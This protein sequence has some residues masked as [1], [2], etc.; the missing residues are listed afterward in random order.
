LNEKEIVI[1]VIYAGIEQSS[2]RS[3]L[4][5]T[6]VTTGGVASRD[7]CIRGAYKNGANAAHVYPKSM[8][9]HI[10]LLTELGSQNTL[11]IGEIKAKLGMFEFVFE[12]TGVDAGMIVIADPTHYDWGSKEEMIAATGANPTHIQSVDNGTYEATWIMPNWLGTL[13]ENEKPTTQML[14]VTSGEIW[15]SDPCYVVRD[16]KWQ[17]YLDKFE[18]GDKMPEGVIC[19]NTGGDGSFT[20]NLKLV[21]RA[22]LSG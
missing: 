19:I 1:G 18:Y 9:D 17:A 13:E 5:Y 11:S 15:I 7:S 16:S 8:V 12:E 22:D 10:S 14:K 4:V 21:R 6:Q 3:Q 2:Y 20:V